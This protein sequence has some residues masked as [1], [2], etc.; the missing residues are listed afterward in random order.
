MTKRK[1]EVLLERLWA[2]LGGSPDGPTG[3]VFDGTGPFLPSVFE[4][5]ALAA[6]SVALAT[7][8]AAD[9]FA[10]RTGA[11]RRAVT[12]DRRHAAVAFRSERYLEARGWQ[13]PAVWDPIAGD[14][15]ARDGFVRLHTNYR[16]HREAALR[17][18]AVPESREAVTQA[19]R[20]WSAEA[21]ESAV[22]DAGGAAAMMRTAEEHAAHAQGQAIRREPLFA[23]S[24]LAAGS[25]E[26]PAASRPL[27][28]VRVLDLTRVIAGPVCTRFLS[29]HG[30]DV[31]RVDPPGFEE[32][33]ALLGD[34]T[35]GKRRTALDLRTGEGRETFGRLVRG[36]DVLVV[37]Y[38]ADALDRLG[39]G[40]DF[41]A[42]V[43]PGLVTV[44]LDAYGWTG[45]WSRRRGFDSLV[46]MTTGIAAKGRDAMGAA[47]PFPLPAQALDHGLG[48]L[49]AAAA[50]RALGRR[51]ADG[52]GAE[53]RLSLARTAELLWELGTDGDPKARDLDPSDA[54]PYLESVDTPWGPIGR[55]RC[56]GSID[57]LQAGWSIVPGPLGVDP[58][59]WGT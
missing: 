29:A 5:D 25:R 54:E 14:Y 15:E 19:V 12:V 13:L 9:L 26:L 49:A 40:A 55:V 24:P 23:W 28:G 44:L 52:E 18:L 10:A 27:G 47:K 4:V 51:L 31:L 7:L 33:G 43:N 6:G 48:Y 56:P 59:G 57:G 1:D 34:T 32:V 53:V 16:N 8:A 35:G 45:P 3:V 30:A 11:P 21:L 22:V 38:R 17:V 46:Q 58:A 20:S 36:A 42:R 50:C 39:L 2:D 41:R 37:G